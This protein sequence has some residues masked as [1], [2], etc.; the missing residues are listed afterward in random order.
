MGAVA[1]A[2]DAA[3]GAAA[4]AAVGEHLG[5]RRLAEAEVA[6]ELEGF[7]GDGELGGEDEVVEDLGDL[8]AAERAEVDDGCAECGENGAALFDGA[9]SP[10][11]MSMTRTRRAAFP[12]RSRAFATAYLLASLLIL[13][14]RLA[15]LEP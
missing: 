9:A 1:A 7:E 10:R 3:G 5:D 8:A 4:A 13:I 14:A 11:T 12:P 6:G 2:G 15:I